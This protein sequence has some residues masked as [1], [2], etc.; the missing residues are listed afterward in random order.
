[1]YVELVQG[2]AERIWSGERISHD[3]EPYELFFAMDN[4]PLNGC[5]EIYDE[6]SLVILMVW[7]FCGNSGSAQ[8]SGQL[9]SVGRVEGSIFVLLLFVYRESQYISCKY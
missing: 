7:P 4:L 5:N 3:I 8:F 6:F 9:K 1:M 2:I